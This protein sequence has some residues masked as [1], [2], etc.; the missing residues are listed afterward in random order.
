MFH[1]IETSGGPSVQD[2]DYP[3]A[4]N[5]KVLRIYKLYNYFTFS[6]SPALEILFRSHCGSSVMVNRLGRKCSHIMI[7]LIEDCDE[8][9]ACVE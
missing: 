8:D 6:G 5:I 3:G 1:Y 4:L 9:E 2:L 7:I